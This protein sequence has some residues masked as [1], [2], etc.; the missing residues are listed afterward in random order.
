MIIFIPKN[1]ILYSTHSNNIFDK[2][3]NIIDCLFHPSEKENDYVTNLILKKDILLSL[4]IELKITPNK[5]IPKC[6]IKEFTKT[7]KFKREIE[8]YKNYEIIIMNKI[9]DKNLNGF[10]EMQMPYNGELKIKLINESNLF[11]IKTE[12]LNVNWQKEIVNGVKILSPNYLLFFNKYTMINVNNSLKKSIDLYLE[13]INKSKY[14]FT[15]TL[16]LLFRD[17]KYSFQPEII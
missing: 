1:T 13:N 10:I 6:A 12:L 3:K 16:D 11:D 5:V 14:K 7:D 15:K 9:K 8:I 2:N 17:V 4:Q